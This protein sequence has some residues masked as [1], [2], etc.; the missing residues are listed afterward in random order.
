METC[1]ARFEA[2]T[3]EEVLKHVELHAAIAHNEDPAS[4]PSE[5][6]AKLR[7]LIRKV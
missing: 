4:W 6:R 5:E 7:S 1:P 3:E 2:S